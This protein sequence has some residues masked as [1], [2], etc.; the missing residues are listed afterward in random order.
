VR[1]ILILVLLGAALMTT[2]PAGAKPGALDPLFG[3]DGIVTAFPDGAV[4]TAV[5]IDAARR[6]TAVGYTVDE[7]ADVVV[8]RFLPDGTL[9]P[10]FG[11]N[12]RARFDLGG[13]DD[14]FDVAVTPAGGMAITG[15]RTRGEDHMFVLRVRPNG[16]RKP[17]FGNRGL[18]LVDFDKPRQSPGTIAFTPQGR[19]VIGGYTS[20]GVLSRS[21]FARLSATGTLDQG[22]GGDGRASFEI[23][24][25]SEQVNDLLVLPGGS[26]VAAGVAE[27][28][29][30]PR[31]SLVKVTGAGR[32]DTSFGVG[33]DGASMIDV[34]TG[35]DAANALTTASD[36]D[37]LLAGSAG[38]NGD[39]AVV[40]T[41]PDGTP[42]PAYG[43]NG[44]V[45]LPLAHAFEEATDIVSR[46]ARAL[47]VG[48]I[49]G[50]G[51]DI[52]VVRLKA[53]GRLDTTFDGD[54]IVRI[55]VSGGIDV[56]AAAALQDNGKLVIAGQTWRGGV[57]RFVLAR[58]L[59]S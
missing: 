37:F 28:A 14:A 8:A 47:V 9:D 48:R 46:G 18:T 51:D 42:D 19:I 41:H 36:G 54:G 16:T 12:G 33:R 2:L 40:A 49:H 22:F 31:F 53:A 50:V 4:A 24:T 38:A 39:W 15:R 44:R 17:G 11:T 45:V 23:G 7:H 30:D 35:P 1:R 29:Q 32:L 59:T 5:G 20:N 58:I 6:I 26:I 10:A 56:A 52:G 34:E 13:I 21:A 55:D 27:N 57:P 43:S 3:G 25:G